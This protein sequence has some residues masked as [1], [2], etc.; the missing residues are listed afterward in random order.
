LIFAEDRL[1]NIAN[2]G[3]AYWLDYAAIGPFLMGNAAT[4][5]EEDFSLR[6]NM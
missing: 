6:A 5:Q 1:W 3:W 4:F 2:P